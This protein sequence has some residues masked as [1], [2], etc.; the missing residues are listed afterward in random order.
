MYDFGAR[1]YDVAGVPMWTSIDPLCEKYYSMSPYNYCGGNPVNAIDPNGCD[2]ISAKYGDE[3]FVY[4]DSRIK[5]KDD[6][7]KVYYD[8]E[9]R[10]YY[11]IQY[12]GATGEVFR[13]TK[14]GLTT[15][16]TLNND[17]SFADAAGNLLDN[18][19]SIDGLLHIGNERMYDI[20]DKEK[21][22]SNWYGSYLGPNN[23]EMKIGEECYP[24]YA[25]TKD[26]ILIMQWD[27]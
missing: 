1:L 8:D 14:D 15:Y 25:M 17:G 20:M 23:P 16:Y 10:E 7:V 19:V 22:K 11:D 24:F 6:I 3:L 13:N 26:M 2:W 27:L 21:R 12:V 4:Y 5:N 18:E 9:Y